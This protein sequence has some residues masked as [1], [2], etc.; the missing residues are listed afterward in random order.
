MMETL[1][2]VSLVVGGGVALLSAFGDFLDFGGVDV[3]ADFDADLDFDTDVDAG[4]DGHAPSAAIFS[5]RSLVFSLFGFGAVGT[6]LT[7]LGSA[8][9]APT[10]IV[11]AA[12]AGLVVGYLVGAFLAYL[13][14]SDTGARAGD[15]S[16]L[17]LTGR[18]TLPLRPD[19]P[20]QVVVAR[21]NREHTVRALPHEST[22]GDPRAW[23][24][25]VV[26]D[27]KDGIARVGPLR[28][29]DEALLMEPDGRA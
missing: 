11:L 29:S 7:A 15:E 26:I 12:G 17:G 28:P 10:T 18:V 5:L 24:T 19:A 21:G 3:D 23:R 8:P 25:V 2:L 6:A 27:M 20:G 16:Y 4:I 14:R 9:S 1:Y 22:S 13:K